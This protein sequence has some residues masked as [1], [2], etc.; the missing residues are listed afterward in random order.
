MVDRHKNPQVQVRVPATERD[1]WR[2]L[3]GEAVRLGLATATARLAADTGILEAHWTQLA[4]ALPA[5]HDHWPGPDA[6]PET[7]EELLAWMV[8]LI[9][10]VGALITNL[11]ATTQQLAQARADLAAV[12]AEHRTLTQSE[13]E[14]YTAQLAALKDAVEQEQRTW[15]LTRRAR[16]LVMDLARDDWTT[17]DLGYWAR[18]IRAAG[19][20]PDTY[21]QLWEE[22]GGIEHAIRALEPEVQKLERLRQQIMTEIGQLQQQAQAAADGTEQARARQ[23]KAHTGLTQAQRAVEAAQATARQWRQIAE[24]LGWWIPDIGQTWTAVG[25]RPDG[26]ERALAATLLLH[27]VQREGD[28]TLTLPGQSDPRHF[29]LP[30]IR[31]SLSEL[32][33]LLAPPELAQQIFTRLQQATAPAPPQAEPEDPAQE[34]IS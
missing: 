31:V 4:Q 18:L 28:A 5:I 29:R 9:P 24:G 12:Q 17:E 25:D 8:D 26:M 34:A 3:F 22:F 33:G 1:D 23:D 6:P 20:T 11:E 14:A 19:V 13:S 21:A 15:H 27:A 2:A 32:I 10:Q 30:G 7:P 16:D